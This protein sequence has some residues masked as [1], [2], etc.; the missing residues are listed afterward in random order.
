M[1]KFTS[2]GVPVFPPAESVYD[3]K[4]YFAGHKEFRSKSPKVCQSNEPLANDIGSSVELTPKEVKTSVTKKT[5]LIRLYSVDETKPSLSLIQKFTRASESR[6]SF[7][8]SITQ[9]DSVALN[10][11]ELEETLYKAARQELLNKNSN[12]NA[13]KESYNIEE[14]EEF[15]F[16]QNWINKL[17]ENDID[18][19]DSSTQI[20]KSPC[21]VKAAFDGNVF[22]F[23]SYVLEDIKE[24][25][26]PVKSTSE[27][28]QKNN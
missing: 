20:K 28:S 8:K 17:V 15:V 5:P 11:S 16:D 6:F 24:T 18:S 3:K 22:K 13:G 4:Y 19:V 27:N 23:Y 26:E 10:E 2:K 9:S 14:D 7:A 12:T 21:K 1:K 25:K